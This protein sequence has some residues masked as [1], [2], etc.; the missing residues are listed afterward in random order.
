MLYQD[1]YG[2]LIIDDRPTPARFWIEDERKKSEERK[3]NAERYAAM[4]AMVDAV[5]RDELAEYVEFV[6][7]AAADE[8]A[9]FGS[10]EMEPQFNWSRKATPDE[11]G[12][13]RAM[14]DI[15]AFEGEENIPADLY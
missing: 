11:R 2:N 5:E 3:A 6:E 4:C 14:L 10:I 15:I 1:K 8:L 12:W 13:S 9:A 7:S